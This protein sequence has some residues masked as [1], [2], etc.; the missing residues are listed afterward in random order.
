[1]VDGLTVLQ[2]RKIGGSAFQEL[3]S[4]RQML[5]VYGLM[6]SGWVVISAI[7]DRTGE[8]GSPVTV[9]L[10]RGSEAAIVLA[11]G[12]VGGFTDGLAGMLGD[13]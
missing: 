6:A 11:D 1:M 2:V 13:E 4:R 10:K 12:T 9:L 7:E 3:M 5:R 8:S